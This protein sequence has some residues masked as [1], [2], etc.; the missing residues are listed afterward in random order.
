MTTYMAAER[1]E[2]HY[3]VYRYLMVL[4]L[5]VRHVVYRVCFVPHFATEE[6]P[7]GA[8]TFC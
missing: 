7:F 3:H 1:V 6:G 2:I 5:S 4:S 8:E